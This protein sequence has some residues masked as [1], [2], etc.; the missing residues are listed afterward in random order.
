MGVCLL[1]RDLVLGAKECTGHGRHVATQHP[2]RDGSSLVREAIRRNH[3][4][5]HDLM[6]NGTQELLVVVVVIISGIIAAITSMSVVS[7]ETHIVE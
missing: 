1:V 6:L 7:S 5:A 4:V 2:L 3:R